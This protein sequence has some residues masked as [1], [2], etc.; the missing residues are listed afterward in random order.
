MRYIVMLWALPLVLFWGW[1]GLSYYNMHFGYV[2]LTRQFHDV[3][4]E[5]YG[6]L[7]GLDPATIPWLLV[8]AL[9]FDTF[10]LLGIW[11]FRRR[12]EIAA[13]TRRLRQRYVSVESAPGA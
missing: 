11:A 2:A 12:R 4:F 5:L 7:L 1:F 9:V 13:G 10:L 8:R 6:E 3:I